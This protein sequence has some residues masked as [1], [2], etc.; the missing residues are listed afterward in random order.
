VRR[1]QPLLPHGNAVL[2]AKEYQ[3]LKGE[4]E[5]FEELSDAVTVCMIQSNKDVDLVDSDADEADYVVDVSTTNTQELQLAAG[6]LEFVLA[7]PHLFNVAVST[8]EHAWCLS[9]GY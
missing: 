8:T 1:N 2:T 6:L 9:K 3:E 4:C 7:Q 5:V